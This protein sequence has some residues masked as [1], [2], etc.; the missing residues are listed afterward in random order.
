MSDKF[1]ITTAGGAP[2]A[3]TAPTHSNDSGGSDREGRLYTRRIS[4]EPRITPNK[5]KYAREVELNLVTER[6]TRIGRNEEL[7]VMRHNPKGR[8][9]E[10]PPTPE[11]N[12]AELPA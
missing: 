3:A 1:N 11:P 2:P 7:P 6:T 5:R 9:V 8:R 4:D 12:K 10:R